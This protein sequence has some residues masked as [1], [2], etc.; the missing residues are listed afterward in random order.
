MPRVLALILLLAASGSFAEADH[1]RPH[2]A[3]FP[4]KHVIFIVKENR[5]FD[6]YFGKFPGADGATTGRL[7]DGTIITLGPLSDGP[8]GAEHSWDAALLAYHNGAMDQFD[9]IPGAEGGSRNMVQASEADI[10]NY[11]KLAREF[12]LSDNFFSSLHGPSFPNHLYTIA[13]QSGGAQDN[14][15]PFPDYPPPPL[16]DPCPSSTTCPFPGEPGL[17]PSDLPPYTGGG[18]WGCDTDIRAMVT[19]LDQEGEVEVIYP[20]FDFPTLGDELTE[21]GVS[22]KMYAPPPPDHEHQG[23]GYQWT[24]YDAIRHIRDSEEWQEHVVP[25]EQFVVDA[26]NGRLP[27][28]SWVSIPIDV[29]EHPPSPICDGE[30]WTVSLLQALASG[31]QW[32]TS[33]VFLTWDDFGGFYDHVAPTQIDRFGLGFRVPLIVIS[34]YAKRGQ[35]DHTR[36]EFSSVLKFVETNWNLPS[37]TNRDAD[38]PDMTQVFDFDQRPRHPPR[39]RQRDDCRKF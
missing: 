2:R 5:T 3:R 23:T 13:A 30:N 19:I 16:V 8:Q 38:S 7:S 37:L 32:K 25:T 10:P 31:P 18:V 9:V 15:R 11:W 35:I 1:H 27:A 29:T 6:N 14:P 17:E 12:V 36:A 24:A 26:R 21:A 33:A 28:M 20:C 39:L 34:P 4:I 22:W